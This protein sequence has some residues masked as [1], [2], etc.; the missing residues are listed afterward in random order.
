MVGKQVRV[1]CKSK[2]MWYGK[3]LGKDITGVTI[4]RDNG[5]EMFIP[6][7][8]VSNVETSR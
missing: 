2:Q 1:V 3:L 7:S 6:M 8:E 5:Q 4:K